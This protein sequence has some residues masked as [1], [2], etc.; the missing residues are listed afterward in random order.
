MKPCNWIWLDLIKQYR[1]KHS[2]Q[3]QGVLSAQIA[4]PSHLCD[5]DEL[6]CDTSVANTIMIQIRKSK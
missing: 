1:V 4:A 6:N 2:F 3:V 5:C